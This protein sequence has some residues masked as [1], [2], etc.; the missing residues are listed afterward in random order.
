[1]ATRALIARKT[2]N[3]W[4][5]RYHHWDGYPSGLGATLYDIYGRV[6]QGDIDLM[7]KTLLDDHPAGWST[8]NGAD[9]D[10]EPGFNEYRSDRDDNLVDR[11]QCYCHG[12]R[13]EEE[14]FFTSDGKDF[15]GA[16][17]CYVI[18]PDNLS[19]DVLERIYCEDGT[20]ATQFF[21]QDANNVGLPAYWKEIGKVEFNGVEPEWGEM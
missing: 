16:E 11:P 7:L 18:D 17:Y 10:L 5:A 15:G 12:D 4:E 8:I 2:E 6:F 13:D 14:W 3:G 20:H 1:M 19:M 21:G 9:W